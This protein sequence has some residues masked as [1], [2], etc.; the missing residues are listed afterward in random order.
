MFTIDPN[1]WYSNVKGRYYDPLQAKAA[2]N[3]GIH[4]LT[5][6]YVK[7][8]M[9]PW[10]KNNWDWLEIRKGLQPYQQVPGGSDPYYS[11]WNNIF[12]SFYYGVTSK[13]DYDSIKWKKK[14]AIRVIIEWTPA[15]KP[16]G[17]YWIAEHP[18]HGTG[19]DNWSQPGYLW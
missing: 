5:D 1:Y 4:A 7:N 17:R 16:T 10:D 18:L 2:A 14:G 13:Q 11:G 19:Y 8:G 3:W 9:I 12:Y 15:G 6:C